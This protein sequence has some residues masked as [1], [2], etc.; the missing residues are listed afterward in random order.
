MKNFGRG[1]G[2]ALLSLA[3]VFGIVA[4]AG[5]T[6]QAQYRNNGRYDRRD[7]D[8]DR[9]DRNRDW[10]RRRDDD[11]WRRNRDWNRRR[12][13]NSRVYNGRVYNGRVY[14]GGVYNNGRYGGYGNYG[15]SQQELN[16]GYQ[17]GLNTGSSDARRGQSYSPERSH[18]YRDR[19]YSQAFKEGFVRGYDQG[20]RQYAGYGNGRYGNRGYNNGVWGNILGG[21][22]RP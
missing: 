11:D 18:F 7:H 14:N 16:R 19:D 21:I 1:I 3:F 5:N 20:Y 17:Q 15:Y 9:S 13:Y 12:V 2:G 8:N 6:A 10:R 4:V 22:L